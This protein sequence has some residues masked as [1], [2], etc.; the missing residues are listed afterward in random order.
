MGDDIEIVLMHCWTLLLLQTVGP[1]QWELEVN[2]QV[3]NAM[4]FSTTTGFSYVTWLDLTAQ[5]YD[6]MEPINS[7]PTPNPNV[8]NWVYCDISNFQEF[9][10]VSVLY[11][12]RLTKNDIQFESYSPVSNP[13]SSLR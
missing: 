6:F 12:A 7:G 4:L 10:T 2:L 9:T 8:G 11:V 5:T 13:V 1:S 3:V